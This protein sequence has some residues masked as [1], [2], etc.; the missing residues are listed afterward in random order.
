MVALQTVTHCCQQL[1]VEV[2]WV[3]TIADLLA[4]I[5]P[6]PPQCVLLTPDFET[7]EGGYAACAQL[8]THR[9][10]VIWLDPLDHPPSDWDRL[11]PLGVWDVLPLSLPPLLM[12]RRLQ[13]YLQGVPPPSPVNPRQ[14]PSHQKIAKW[15]QAIVEQTAVGINEADLVTGQFIFVNQRFCDLLGYS[16]AELRMMT[17]KQVT[18]P[19]DLQANA[20]KMAQLYR[21]ELPFI[22]LEKRYLAKSGEVVWTEVALSLLRDDQGQPFA[23]L[24]VVLDVRDRKQAEHALRASEVMQQAVLGAL[25]DLLMRVDANGVYLELIPTSSALMNAWREPGSLVGHSVLDTGTPEHAQTKLA[26]IRQAI[27]T[28]ERQIYEQTLTIQGKVQYEEVRIVKTGVD[29]ALIMVRDVSAQKRAEQQFRQILLWEEACSRILREMRQSSGMERIFRTVV[30]ELRGALGC[31]RVVLYRFRADWSGDFV[32][33]SVAA[34]WVALMQSNENVPQS[35][36]KHDRCIVQSLSSADRIALTDTYLQN[37]QG[38]RY[39]SGSNCF[40]VNDIY[41]AGFDDCYLTLLESFQARAYLTVPV[42]CG[43]QLWGLLGTYYNHSPHHWQPAEVSMVVR[44]GEQLGIALNQAALVDQLHQQTQHR[45]QA[46]AE[47]DRAHQAKSELLAH[48]SHELKT[49]L[50]IILGAAQVMAQETNLS[51]H[52]VMN[53]KTILRSGEHLLSVINMVLDLTRLQAKRMP[54]QLHPLSLPK[55]LRD[56][57]AMLRPQAMMKGLQLQLQ[58]APDL[59]LQ[60]STDEIKV[61]QVLLNLLH[62][63]VKFT[64][65]GY[66]RVTAAIASPPDAPAQLTVQVQDTGK[67]VPPEW[68]ARIFDVFE[69]GQSDRSISGTGLGLAICQEYVALL[70]GAIS[71]TSAVD[72]GSTFTI[73]LPVTILTPAASKDVTLAA[74]S[75][76]MPATSPEAPLPWLQDLPKPVLEA[77]HHAA[78]CCDD[79]ALYRLVEALPPHSVNLKAALLRQIEKLHFSTITGW[80]APLL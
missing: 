27:A 57:M 37:T 18:L 22:T 68:Q 56:V 63:A 38:G 9:L 32:A 64:D 59:P 17:Y 19:T 58:L 43:Q 26:K 69:Q 23:D 6:I 7:P 52:Q 12:Q 44:T 25:P 1:Q 10:P 45:Q 62:N 30:R 13:G 42:F 21:G 49:P 48:M 66:I 65:Q 76:W 41:T 78:R 71:L 60:I 39:N 5:A 54:I 79:V 77:L 28:G 2:V 75:T 51:E 8:P 74:Q 33:E 3:H 55:L 11:V 31:D 73:V 4:Q 34:G 40:Q 36:L 50:N 61:R 16:A 35:G 20:T 72:Q 67:G 70:G 15:A 47:A 53:L 24:A 29:E 80:I 14:H 46:Q